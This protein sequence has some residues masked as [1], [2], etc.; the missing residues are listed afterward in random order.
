VFELAF[1]VPPA[2]ALGSI[3][4]H[5]LDGDGLLDFV[6]TAEGTVSAYDHFGALLWIESAS[7]HLP[8][9]A[10]GGSGYP[11]RHAPGAIAADVDGDGRSEIAFIGDDGIVRIRDGAS[12]APVNAGAEAAF[13][14]P[15]AEAPNANPS[16]HERRWNKQ[17]YRRIK[18]NWNYYS[19]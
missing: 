4:V 14:F 2:T 18:Q 7:I 16:A 8:D 10:N 17:Y 9:A 6:V 19:P 1:P 5:E 12:G 3:F 11:G 15:G 13:T